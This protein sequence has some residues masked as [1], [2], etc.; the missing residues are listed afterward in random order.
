MPPVGEMPRATIA[1]DMSITLMQFARWLHVLGVVV[2]VG[3][4]FFAHMALRPSVQALEPPARL[5]L[6]A[7][8]LKRF[9]TWV[10][11]AVLA[12]LASGF[13]MVAMLGGFDA[14]NRWVASMAVAGLVMVA[15]YLW[16]VLAPFRALRN[17]AAAS[18]WP[19][20]G[21]AMKRVRHL[22]AVNLGLGILV[23]TF[24]ILAR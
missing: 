18:D 21:A 23:I 16:L 13:G 19:A 2:W 22:V 6:L 8:T 14:V 12:I 1:H 7:A 5:T 24:G 3:G 20:A 11:V 9:V 15:I 4:M 10:G 17:A